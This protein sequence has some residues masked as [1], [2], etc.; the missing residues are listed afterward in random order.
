M[1]LTNAI[2]LKNHKKSVF[3]NLPAC[4]L[5]HLSFCRSLVNNSSFAYK[6]FHLRKALL[7][8]VHRYQNRDI[9]GPY[10]LLLAKILIFLRKLG[11]KFKRVVFPKLQ[12]K[13]KNIHMRQTFGNY[14]V[15]GFL[16]RHQ[17]FGLPYTR[18][19]SRYWVYRLKQ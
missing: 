11:Y 9:R 4:R 15:V 7:L 2:D 14:F 8:S 17:F 3:Y 13:L 16:I 18:I 1:Q 6:L 19:L 5:Q 10:T 12:K